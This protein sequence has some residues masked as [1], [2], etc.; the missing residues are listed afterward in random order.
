[1]IT[2]H[3]SEPDGKLWKLTANTNRPYRMVCKAHSTTTD[4]QEKTL[5][6]R[7]ISQVLHIVK[8]FASF[9][10]YSRSVWVCVCVR[11]VK[12]HVGALYNWS[13]LS[14]MQ[15]H[16]KQCLELI[17]IHVCWKGL[18]L[19]LFNKRIHLLEQNEI[20]ITSIF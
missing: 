7:Y 4:Y 12:H 19:Y 14:L 2:I 6:G 5:T 3:Q 9:I 17:I 18:N 8:T 20:M 15:C 16:L 11:R 1:V 10:L 13:F